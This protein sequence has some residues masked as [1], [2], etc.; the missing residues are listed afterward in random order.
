MNKMF[1]AIVMIV[2]IGALT[3]SIGLRGVLAQENTVTGDDIAWSGGNPWFC[4]CNHGGTPGADNDYEVG[5]SVTATYGSS[6][7]FDYGSWYWMDCAGGSLYGGTDTTNVYQ[8]ETPMDIW[9]NVNGGTG[10]EGYDF[11]YPTWSVPPPDGNYYTW[12]VGYGMQG[13]LNN[14][15]SVEGETM[16]SFYQVTNVGNVLWQTA[17]TQTPSGQSGNGYEYLT[18]YW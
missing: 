9:A 1:T 11:T 17:I 15:N 8:Q 12:F 2:V 3:L 18:A 13:S 16:A 5:L 6:D 4:E 7:V 10:N 14:V